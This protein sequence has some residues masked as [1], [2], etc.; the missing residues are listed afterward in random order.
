MGAGLSGDDFPHWRSA[1]RAARRIAPK[2][3]GFG[4]RV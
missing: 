4:D 2:G 3:E 1:L